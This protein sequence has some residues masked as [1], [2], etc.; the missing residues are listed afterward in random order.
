MTERSS[1]QRPRLPDRR[2]ARTQ[3]RGDQPVSE[4][5]RRNLHQFRATR[6]GDSL[7]AAPSQIGSYTVLASFAD[8]PTT[9]ARRRLPASRSPRHAGAHVEPT[10]ADSLWHA[11]GYCPVRCS[12][13]RPGELIRIRRPLGTILYAGNDQTLSAIF[14]PQ[15]TVDYATVTVTTRSA[16]EQATPTFEG[17]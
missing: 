2:F 10:I 4:L 12:G 15:D 7:S 8:S 11:A 14:T 5:L 6:R 17:Q 9:R 1:W 16:V 13:R 3:P